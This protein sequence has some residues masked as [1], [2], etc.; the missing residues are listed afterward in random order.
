MVGAVSAQ[1]VS[2]SPTALSLAGIVGGSPVSQLLNISAAGGYTTVA[3]LPSHSWLSATPSSG[4]TPLQV[5]VTA[6]PAGLAAGTYTDNNFR[7][8]TST[9][10]VTVPITFVV[11]SITVT[12]TSLSF[13]YTMGTQINPPG[14]FLTVN[15][16]SLNFTA[17]ATTSS[18]GNWLVATPTG[19]QVY[20]ITDPNVLSGL[21]AGT[22][23][24]A[25]NITQAGSTAV[26]VPV[27]LT[28]TPQ[29][30]VTVSP[31]SVNL[32][33]QIGGLNNQ[34][35]QQAVTF[36]TSSVT[37]LP[38]Q[39][40]TPSVSPNPS[41]GNW[42]LVSPTSGTIPAGGSA[43]AAI[44]YITTANLPA[45]SYSGTVPV[46]ATGGQISTSS[47][48]VN[49]FV[50]ASP[51][52]IVPT[53]A[54]NFGYELGGAV[55]AAQSVTAQSTA[56]AA[57]STTGQ[58]PITVSATTASGGSWLSVLP[59]ANLNTGTPF[60]VTANP[61]NLLPG[62]YTG[63]V[64]V[65]PGFGAVSG[66]GAQTIAVTLTVANDPAIVANT[67]TIA[68]PYQI[69]QSSPAAQTVSL[70]SSTGAPLNYSVTSAETSCS[71]VNWLTLGGSTTGAT[72]ASFSVTPSNLASLSAGTCTGTVTVTA[73]N[74]A[75]GN[76]AIN[77][78]L[79]IPVT[80]FVSSTPLLVVSPATLAFSSPVSGA[81]STQQILVNSTNPSSAITYTVSETTNSG[82]NNWL[83]VG[84]L[85]GNTSPGNNI[86]NVSVNPGLLSAALRAIHSGTVTIRTWQPG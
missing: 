80:L 25:V 83:T 57:S 64:T 55:P 29:P 35:A 2:I 65:A 5:T 19:S 61:V 30:P 76:A 1:T 8:V 46:T 66:N 75:T 85:T 33:Y 15:G 54:L 9:Q 6:N 51:L 45:G 36:T 48:P 32:N 56:V 21:S 70:T 34:G 27:T 41:G 24:G 69:G 59:A 67:N 40:G 82:G 38:F 50:S 81:T 84:P 16:Q 49:L 60:S 28:V 74:P 71:T 31:S 37:A 73:I 77:S 4:V 63:T 26:S 62:T 86:V 20:V 10:T 22:Y 12:P 44:S 17:S 13:A 58:M 53:Q 68:F 43:Q 52:L 47:I 11:G 78:P 42:I 3:V 7:V 14:Q 23:Q 39:F 18:G 72:N 79:V